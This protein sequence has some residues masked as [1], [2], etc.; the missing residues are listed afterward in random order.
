MRSI[1]L[2]DASTHPHLHEATFQSLC[3]PSRSAAPSRPSRLE[4]SH[5]L[6]APP[7]P[8][9]RRRNTLRTFY[10]HLVTLERTPR[11]HSRSL[12]VTPR[13]LVC[14]APR[15]R[16]LATTTPQPPPRVLSRTR[17]ATRAVQNYHTR[18]P[19]TGHRRYRDARAPR[20]RRLA[21]PLRATAD[22]PRMT[23][24]APT[25]TPPRVDARPRARAATHARHRAS[26]ASRAAMTPSRPRVADADVDDSL[27]SNPSCVSPPRLTPSRAVNVRNA[28][29]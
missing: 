29:Q 14:P 19:R 18:A 17:D 10:T 25:P 1:H 2:R 27:Q 16:R 7:S 13:V 26:S 12:R 24:Q 6:F 21:P 8:N 28:T 4:H 11:V 23:L 3:V 20:E 15:T 5:P 22:H 9:R